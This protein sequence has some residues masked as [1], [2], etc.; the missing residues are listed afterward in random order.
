MSELKGGD[1]SE[2]VID[3]TE[4]ITAEN[5][6]EIDGLVFSNLSYFPF[7]DSR[8]T[9][10][11]D[12][13][14]NGISISGL[15]E[16][17][18][19]SNVETNHDKLAF[20]EAIS[21]SER[22]SE[23]IVTDLAACNGDTM[24]DAGRIGTMP[25]DAQWAAMTIRINDG[26]D[27]SVIAMRGTA[28]ELGWQ[29]DLELG[30]ETDGTT[31]QKLSR[32]YLSANDSDNIIL[33]GHSKGGNDVSSAY[34]MSDK[35]VRDRVI[36]VD[37]YDGPGNNPELIDNYRE[38]Y[39]E[40]SKK[41]KN[42]YPKDSVVGQL[43]EDAP[44]K[45]IYVDAEIKNHTEIPIIGEHDPYS[46]LIDPDRMN[47]LSHT[48]QSWESD[49]INRILDSSLADM[50]AGE[51]AL[52]MQALISAG[53]P[54]IL[55]KRAIDKET[56]DKFGTSLMNFPSSSL[57]EK[58]TALKL[59]RN[60][61]S[62]F[63]QYGL[64]RALDFKI[65][66]AEEFMYQTK[67]C[68]DDFFR[69]FG[70][71]AEDAWNAHWYGLLNWFGISD[72]EYKYIHD[73]DNTPVYDF[74][75]RSQGEYAD[76]VHT[77]NLF[78]VDTDSLTEGA[79]ELRECSNSINA[80]AGRLR[81]SRNSISGIGRILAEIP[82]DILILRTK[83]RAYEAERMSEILNNCAQSYRDTENCILAKIS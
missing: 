83:K 27:T 52:V 67:D 81:E 55:D 49:A 66:N 5:Y 17:I 54:S 50:T 22:Y 62:E 56:W 53:I 82:L 6:N 24:W 37:N 7:E 11:R 16:K 60:L 14:E 44:G 80:C 15:A 74:G 63:R 64:I 12:E 48:E 9:W 21:K 70:N 51:K 2:Y 71:S 65:P 25:D 31:A 29:E 10:T 23:C 79:G 77:T 61:I 75:D 57:E 72:K 4:K 69:N 33:T 73:T 58:W 26:T 78:W 46:W 30:Y 32:D 47:R 42:Y 43:L 34:M 13:L 45:N 68:F 18:I 3:V 39:D 20:I 41:Q 38:G 28:S 8:I 1:I 36:R 35:D 59:S 40:L 19:E 76:N